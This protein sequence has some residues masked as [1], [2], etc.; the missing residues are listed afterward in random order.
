MSQ[1][2]VP[3]N[4]NNPLGIFNQAVIV[5]A[6]QVGCLT[7]LIILAALI[8]GLLLDRLLN[9]RPLFTILFMV[10]SM[11][12]TWVAILWVVNRSK[13]RFNIKPASKASPKS[14][15]EEAERDRD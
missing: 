4:N 5:V 13:D 3:S 12:L 1:E 2:R 8:L 11:P 15:W 9:T 7:F 10:G 6:G 14:D